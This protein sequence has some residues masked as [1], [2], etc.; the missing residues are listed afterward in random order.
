MGWLH[1]LRFE[2]MMV[3]KDGVGE[4]GFCYHKRKNEMR[5][6]MFKPALPGSMPH[7][8]PDPITLTIMMNA[9]NPIEAMAA[10]RAGEEAD[11]APR[12]GS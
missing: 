4:F 10:L 1:R 6:V 12:S 9:D 11:D 8:I 2:H 3:V 7:F 5:G